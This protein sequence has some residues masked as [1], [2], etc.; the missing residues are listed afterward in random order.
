MIL[1]LHAFSFTAQIF[2]RYYF[3]ENPAVLSCL[4]S[5]VFFPLILPDNHTAKLGIFLNIN[6]ICPYLSSR[7]RN[8]VIGPGNKFTFSIARML[9][10]CLLISSEFH[11]NTEHEKWDNNTV[12]KTAQVFTVE[13]CKLVVILHPRSI[14]AYFLCFTW[15]E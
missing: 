7:S 1:F 6:H 10:N 13:W 9:L 8:K 5:H 4:S 15:F 14:Y 3:H 12:R 2:T 11:L